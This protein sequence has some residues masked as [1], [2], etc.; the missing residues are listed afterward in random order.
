MHARALEA[1]LSKGRCVFLKSKESQSF[2]LSAELT[3][4][5][6]G[7]VLLFISFDR[8][9]KTSPS[10]ERV[11]TS[12]VNEPVFPEPERARAFKNSTERVQNFTEPDRA[13]DPRA[14][15]EN[16]KYIKY[17]FPKKNN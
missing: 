14:R 17:F 11:K 10:S 5:F 13:R 15:A 7:S 4:G 9:S 1:K 12:D 8:L 3:G 2:A 6:Y 16:Y